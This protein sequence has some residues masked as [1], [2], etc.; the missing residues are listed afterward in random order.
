M[1]TQIVTVDEDGRLRL[2]DD[3]AAR[4]RDRMVLLTD[5]GERLVMRELAAPRPGTYHGRGPGTSEGC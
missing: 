2:P 1:A 4:W 5:L 3:V